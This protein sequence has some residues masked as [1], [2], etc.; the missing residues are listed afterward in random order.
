M[1]QFKDEQAFV[2]QEEWVID[3]SRLKLHVHFPIKCTA[4]GE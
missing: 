4:R 2:D 3:E 1:D